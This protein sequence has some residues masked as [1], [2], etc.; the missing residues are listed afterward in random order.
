L[1]EF[2]IGPAEAGKKVL[3]Y[4]RQLLPGVP[5][6]GIHKMVRTG[7]VKRN[8]KRAK[9]DDV[10]AEGDVIRLYMA[11]EDF[12]QV[13]KPAK[14]FHGVSRAIDVV[15]EDSDM[16]IVN[17]PLGLLTH[18]AQG[19]HKETLAN[20]VLAYLYDKGELHSQVFTPSPVNRLDRNTSGLVLFGKTHEATRTLAEQLR[21]HRIRK[22]YLAIV[23]GQPSERGEID[24]QLT[25]D[26][27]RNVTRVAEEGKPARTLY[28]RRATAGSTSVVKVELISGRTHQIRAH[29]AHIG[30]PLW[31]DVKYG[32]RSRNGEHHQWLHAA[33]LSFPDGR[34]VH[35]PLPEAFRRTLL[36]LGY[37]RQ[38]I[39]QIEKF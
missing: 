35:A 12:A 20:R 26:V 27:K 29:F 36:Q 18:G 38:D 23:K 19:E 33:W 16:L 21:D 28:E 32:G 5:L 2:S 11:E 34:V 10:L 3:R 22:W 15:Y 4:V 31:N 17:K 24:A 14:K 30:H 13:S 1:I 8:G 39:E 7:R 37:T 6:S 9:A 25:R